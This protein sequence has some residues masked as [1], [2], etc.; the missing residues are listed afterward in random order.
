VNDGINDGMMAIEFIHDGHDAVLE[1]LFGC[2]TDV[3][4][5]ER[6]SLEK[7]PSMR[8]SQQP[9]VGVKVNSNRPAG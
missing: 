1:F 7:K 2:D 8:L 3:P 5:H 6:V 9:C 4:Q